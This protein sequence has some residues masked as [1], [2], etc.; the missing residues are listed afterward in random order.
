MFPNPTNLIAATLAL[1]TFASLAKAQEHNPDFVDRV[2]ELTNAERRANGLPELRVSGYLVQSAQSHADDQSRRNYVAHDTPEGMTPRDRILAVGYDSQSYTGENLYNWFGDPTKITP[3]AAV[4]WWMNSPGHRANILDARYTEIGV[5]LAI[6]VANGMHIYVQNFGSSPTTGVGGWG[7]I[8][9]SASTSAYGAASGRDSAA[10][11]L[12]AAMQMCSSNAEDCVLAMSY[13]KGCG[14][15][16]R[17]PS[18][19]AWGAGMAGGDGMP[20]RNAAG[21]QARAR[22]VRAGGSSCNEL[23]VA[24]CSR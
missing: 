5:G 6:T 3:Q 12:S 21:A 16:K 8:A 17:D 18:T 10:D 7:A 1:V 15:V 11:A 2:V 24:T 13:R 22:C 19:G 4:A 9:Y 23:V 20:A 14:V